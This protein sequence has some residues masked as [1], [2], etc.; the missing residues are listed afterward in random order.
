MIVFYILFIVKEK[1]KKKIYR[2]FFDFFSSDHYDLNL[3]ILDIFVIFNFQL[4]IN[5]ITLYQSI[6]YTHIYIFFF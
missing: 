5:S 2:H 1:K 3:V 4:Q 6:S